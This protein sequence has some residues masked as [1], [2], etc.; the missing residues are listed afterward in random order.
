MYKKIM[1]LKK[2]QTEKDKPLVLKGFSDITSLI[3]DSK[4]LSKAS[5]VSNTIPNSLYS[6]SADC[7][8]FFEFDKRSKH[9]FFFI[10]G[11]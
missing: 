6:E 1:K 4:H 9:V 5:H 3:Q 8:A 2:K 7:R 11:E 10:L